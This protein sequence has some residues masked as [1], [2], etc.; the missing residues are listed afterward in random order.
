[1]ADKDKRDGTE[2]KAQ[3]RALG[4]YMDKVARGEIK[5]VKPED[6]GKHTVPRWGFTPEERA[7]FERERAEKEKGPQAPKP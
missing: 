4:E 1:M 7:R 6:L 2:D 3:L 5:P